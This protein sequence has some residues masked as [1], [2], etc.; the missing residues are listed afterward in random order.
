[1]RII[2]LAIACFPA[3]LNAQDTLRHFIFG[4]SLIDHRPPLIATPSDETTLPHWLFLLAQ[5]AGTPYAA[6]GQYGFLPQHANLPPI[7]QWGYDIVPGVWESDTE[8]FSA[9]DIDQVLITAGNFMQWQGPAEPYPN[10]PP[11]LTPINATIDIADWVNQQEDSVQIYIYENWP[12]MAPYL[13][14]GSFPPTP[15]DLSTYYNYTRGEFHD[16]WLEYHDSLLIARPDAKIRMIP[17]GPILA[18]LL[19][20]PMLSQVPATEWYEDDA[21][22]GRASLYFLASLITYQAM[23]Q[24]KV[25]AGFSVPSIVRQ[26][27]SSNF[28]AISDTIWNQLLAFNDT[29]GDNRVFFDSPST[30]VDLPVVRSCE[31]GID[32]SSRLKIPAGIPP[33]TEVT[34]TDLNGRTIRNGSIEEATSFSLPTGMYLLRL[35]TEEGSLCRQKLLI[36]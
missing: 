25:P 33:Q 16:W 19:E 28:Q 13:S 11:S 10:E 6:G 23:F 4:H 31:F 24:E 14:G 15:Q 27:I 9:A 34:L 5:E 8:P 7:S 21:P 26:E 29:N 20:S 18:N 17:V 1:M 32:E 12:D 3:F 2:L 35:Q 22:H 36:R 30:H